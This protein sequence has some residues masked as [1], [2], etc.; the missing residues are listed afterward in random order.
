M[1]TQQFLVCGYNM[2]RSMCHVGT[3]RSHT[4]TTSWFRKALKYFL[5]AL[6]GSLSALLQDWT[7]PFAGFKP[8]LRAHVPGSSPSPHCLYQRPHQ[9]HEGTSNE[10]QVETFTTLS[11]VP[12]VEGS[13]CN[14][15]APMMTY[16]QPLFLHCRWKQFW[17]SRR[18]PG[19]PCVPQGDACV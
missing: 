10:S 19:M 2:Q 18:L 16:S 9:I 15:C 8:F 13:H 12:D 1:T 14:N 17:G 6:T 11:Q 7:N 4:C 5:L 3:N